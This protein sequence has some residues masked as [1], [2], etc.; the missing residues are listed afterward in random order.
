MLAELD[1]NTATQQDN[2]WLDDLPIGLLEGGMLHHI[3]PDH[4]GSP[5]KVIQASSNA[6]ICDWPILNNPFGETAPNEDALLA[7]L[8]ISAQTATT[9]I[10]S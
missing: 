2:F 9:V 5:R 8:P 7:T 1:D 10:A 3:Q 4:L 6:A